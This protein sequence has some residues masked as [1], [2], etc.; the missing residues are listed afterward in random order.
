MDPHG[1]GRKDD[2]RHAIAPHPG[3]VI[4]R[5]GEDTQ[6]SLTPEA[7]ADIAR[8]AAQIESDVQAD[9]IGSI[10][11]AVV[12][13]NRVVWTGA[14]G[15]AD[16]DRQIPATPETIYRTGSISKSVTAVLLALMW[17]PTTRIPVSRPMRIVSFIPSVPSRRQ[18]STMLG[19]CQSGSGDWL[20]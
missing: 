19:V 3:V 11:A 1:P 7:E 14:F 16:R 13:G 4:D 20:R 17:L 15:W 9:D 18:P 5:R 2:A 6:T 10:A 12:R 8:F